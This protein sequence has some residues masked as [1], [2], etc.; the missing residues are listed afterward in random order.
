MSSTKNWTTEVL[1][2]LDAI[3]AG[4]KKA[5]YLGA[6]NGNVIPKPHYA[7]PKIYK[8][9]PNPIGREKNHFQ[10]IQRYGKY[11]IVSA[12]LEPDTKSGSKSQ[13]VLIVMGSRTATQQW[14]VPSYE[15]TTPHRYN[16]RYPDPRDLV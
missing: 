12:G 13:L 16:Y 11:L 4:V 14:S 3:D 7:K 1:R 8:R 6:N 10:G 15:T 2:K 9:P 5:Q